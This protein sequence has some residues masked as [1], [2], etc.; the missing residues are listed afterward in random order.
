MNLHEESQRIMPTP[1]H[2]PRSPSAASPARAE[3]KGRPKAHAPLRPRNSWPENDPLRASRRPLHDEEPEEGDE[4]LEEKDEWEEDPDE[5]EEGE[6]TEED[7]E[8]YLPPSLRS[9]REEVTRPIKAKLR[10]RPFQ[11]GRRSLED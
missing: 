11:R 2:E 9:R 6:E 1:Q 8:H 4:D 3:A 10:K 7:Y 5:E